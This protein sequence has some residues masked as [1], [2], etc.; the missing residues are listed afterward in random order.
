MNRL[1]AA[2]LVVALLSPLA[3]AEPRKMLVLK[4]EGRA[5]VATRTK[6]DAAIIK[7]AKT[8]DATVSPG[9][10]TMT[11]A[12]TA[13]GCTPDT[14]ACRD[15]ILGMLAVDEIVYAQVA[16]KP[17]GTEV[18]AYRVARGGV[19]RDAKSMI[20]KTEG[21]DKLDGLAPL[22]FA[23][24]TATLPP[25]V[26]DPPPPTTTTPEPV[27]PP[28]AT[29]PTTT[30]PAPLDN[31]YP[32]PILIDEPRSTSRLPLY[33]A[34]GGGALVL[35]GFLCWGKAGDIQG[36]IDDAPANTAADL[37]AIQDLE[38]SGD[39]YAGGG[40]FLFL[41]GAVL[42]G[43]SAYF[44]IKQRRQRNT[45]T[46]RISPTVFDRGAGIALTIGTP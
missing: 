35:F 15:E 44:L 3:V 45:T 41:A 32:A 19:A 10:I 4:S 40:N 7:L 23:S 42:G 34:I 5:D 1:I 27:P 38:S 36:Q 24:T 11:D 8:T 21:G 20:L 13:V 6:V 18:V 2:T 33:G 43:V 30:T 29:Q 31:A 22:F 9:D 16:P 26:G 12:A 39:A 25:P 46:A 37:T 14:P 17:G 28:T